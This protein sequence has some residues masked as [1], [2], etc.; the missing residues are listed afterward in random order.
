MALRLAA[1]IGAHLAPLL[2]LASGCTRAR[3]DAASRGA[4]PLP[5][6]VRASGVTPPA[7]AEFVS[8]ADTMYGVVVP[9]P[10]RWLEDTLAA[11]TRAWVQSQSAYTDSVLA[12]LRG[13]AR[14]RA[15]VPSWDGRYVALG[16]TAGG[17][18]KAAIVVV[19]AVSGTVLRDGVEDLL[20]TTSGTRYEVSWL[21]DASGFFYPRLA[22]TSSGNGTDRLARGRQFLHK[23]GTPQSADVPVFGFEVSPAVV[24][25]KVDLP[26]RVGTS[27]NSAWLFG[28]VFRSKQN[29][30]DHFAA[31]LPN[32]A[33]PPTWF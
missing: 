26:T 23:M 18:G 4:A 29:G 28:S 19:D 30:T 2:F 10:L 7:P 22:S 24:L 32:G 6:V 17:D 33:K 5:P 14:S 1:D 20:T 31:Q 9:D 3:D 11:N 27:A 8:F 12:R 15:F 13:G 25:D 16:T 21:P